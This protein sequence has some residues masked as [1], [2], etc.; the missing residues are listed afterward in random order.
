MYPSRP[1]DYV[2]SASAS[3]AGSYS[4]RASS[5]SLS[6]I[7]IAFA[8]DA[9][10]VP[11][12][13][14]SMLYSATQTTLGTLN[15]AP[16]LDPNFLLQQITELTHERDTARA[17][18][19]ERTTA[20]HELLLELQKLQAHTEIAPPFVATPAKEDYEDVQNWNGADDN[21]T[22][23]RF[24]FVVDA[25]GQFVGSDR[26]AL[27]SEHG[28][29]CFQELHRRGLLE[30][31]WGANGLLVV[32]LFVNAMERMFAELSLCADHWK[33]KA[34]AR[35]IFPDWVSRRGKEL[36]KDVRGKKRKKEP[37]VDG[38]ESDGDLPAKQPKLQAPPPQVA[39][40]AGKTQAARTAQALQVLQTKTKPP[41][42][43]KL[44][45]PA[46]R[47]AAAAPR[48]VED[49]P[50][51][52]PRA[53]ASPPPRVGLAPTPERAP[54]APAAPASLSEAS[55]D[56][57]AQ[58]ALP[59]AAA[60]SAHVELEPRIPVPELPVPPPPAPRPSLPP[61]K[62]AAVSKDSSSEASKQFRV[63]PLKTA[64]HHIL[65]CEWAA[66]K[67]K[68]Q[69]TMENWE[70]YLSSA[71]GKQAL[72]IVEARAAPK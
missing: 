39:Q 44:S 41:P 36:T 45:R 71:E 47:A 17:A 1:G 22:D 23:G 68:A 43:I 53:A 48:A 67:T 54:D 30:R 52:A 26:T 58:P 15:T 51:P 21:C 57:S 38:G 7:D 13:P 3:S 31:T 72:A 65:R 16:T 60:G 10:A 62:A 40:A 4:S 63:Y 55:Q 69:R 46:P 27:M 34:L 66:D 33:A 5:A 20:Y 37:S 18:L 64:P 11:H 9:F 12:K 56:T 28:K 35:L 59:H 19:E 2:P 25:D 14:D 42:P 8:A 70:A 29:L 50:G 61:A 49:G 32:V 6:P 24:G